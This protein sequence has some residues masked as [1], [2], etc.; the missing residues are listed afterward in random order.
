MTLAVPKQQCGPCMAQI[1]THND[2]LLPEK[3]QYWKQYTK[4]NT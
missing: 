4:Y 3:D 1:D 2:Q